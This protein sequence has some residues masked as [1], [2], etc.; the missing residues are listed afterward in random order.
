MP[1]GSQGK[2]WPAFHSFAWRGTQ[3]SVRCEEQHRP[4]AACYGGRMGTTTFFGTDADIAR[5]WR[6][7]FE[8]PGLRIF[9]DSSR[10]D[11]PNRWFD[12]WDDVSTCLNDGKI[13]LAARPE[14]AGGR[15]LAE[16]VVF[17]AET[18]RELGGK[19]RTILRSPAT[20][21]VQRNNDQ[22]GCLASAWIA[23]WNEKGARQRSAFAEGALDQVDWTRLRS[24][25]GKLQRQVTKSAPAKLQSSPVMADAFERFRLGEIRLW[26]WGE[27][28]TYPSPLVVET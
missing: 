9:E 1:A 10:P 28:C 21:K 3:G 23:C 25:A 7:L 12:S 24:V 13:S 5:V 22:N 15:P 17:T 6:W 8:M 26:A 18:Q 16:E 11:R 20:I 14:A 27:A 19:G 2:A 4:I